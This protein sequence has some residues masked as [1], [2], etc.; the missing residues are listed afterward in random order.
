MPVAAAFS[1]LLFT[2][3]PPVAQLLGCVAVLLCVLA[4]GLESAT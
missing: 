4:S 2:H 1:R 3:A